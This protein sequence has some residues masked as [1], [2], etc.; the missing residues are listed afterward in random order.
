MY[1]IAL[2]SKELF[3]YRGA[4]R[5]IDYLWVQ[6]SLW[7]ELDF[8]LSSSGNREETHEPGL[9]QWQHMEI[10]GEGFSGKLE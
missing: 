6:Q 7:M 5:D 4:T 2:V 1:L 10:I 9:C 8:R 3:M